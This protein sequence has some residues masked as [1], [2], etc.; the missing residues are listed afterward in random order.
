[1]F[2]FVVA[3]VAVVYV[4]VVVVVIQSDYL[5]S[6]TVVCAASDKHHIYFFTHKYTQCLIKV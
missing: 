5:A 3:V 1:M 2:V 4:V 6:Q